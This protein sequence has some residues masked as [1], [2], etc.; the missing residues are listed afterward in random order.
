MP[1]A[2]GGQGTQGTQGTNA[3]GARGARA[4]AGQASARGRRV[5][6]RGGGA[7][8]GQGSTQGRPAGGAS[9]CAGRAGRVRAHGRPDAPAHV[10]SRARG[11]CVRALARLVE[12]V[13]QVEDVGR[14]VAEA[15]LAPGL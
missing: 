15:G 7:C 12:P 9:R 2:C 14:E 3:G 10:T 13:G 4:Y 5:R 6:A 1:F 11:A 8:E